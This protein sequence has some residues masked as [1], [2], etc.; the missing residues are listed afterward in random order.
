LKTVAIVDRTANL[1]DAVTDLV[2]SRFAFNGRSPYSP[3]VILV[4]EFCVLAFVELLVK[5]A[6]SYMG[7]GSQ[8]TKKVLKRGDGPSLLEQIA[9]ADSSHVIVSGTGWAVAQVQDR[10]VP[11]HYLHCA[12]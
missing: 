1:T 11:H 3:D 9:S 10:L 5:E 2:I 8:Q 4:N 12:S 6:P 7:R